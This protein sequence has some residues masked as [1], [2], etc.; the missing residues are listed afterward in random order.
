MTII[1]DIVS[2]FNDENDIELCGDIN[3]END[4]VEIGSSEV[5]DTGIPIKAFVNEVVSHFGYIVTYKKA[6]TAKQ[7]AMS[8]IYGDWE[9]SYNDLPHWMNVAQHFASRTIICYEASR[10]F[11]DGIQDS[12]N[13]ILD[14]VFWAFKPCIEGFAFCK[15]ILQ[16]DGTFLTDKYT[17]TL[18]IAS[19]QDGNRRIFSVPFAI[20]EEETNEA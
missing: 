20:V 10:H 7:L 9:S 1:R 16:V 3:E 19:S 2:D 6:W 5:D 15:P 17:R 8:R 18:L 4:D 11:I 12:N 14:R 13:F